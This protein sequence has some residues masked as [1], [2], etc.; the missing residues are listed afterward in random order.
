MPVEHSTAN[1]QS[2][3]RFECFFHPSGKLTDKGKEM[4]GKYTF[5]TLRLLNFR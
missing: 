3:L 2:I 1:G 5:Q 4:N